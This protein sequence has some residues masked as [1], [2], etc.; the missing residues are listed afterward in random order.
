VT[1]STTLLVA[2]EP[3]SNSGKMKQA[4]DKGIRIVS[5]DEFEAML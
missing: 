1:K 5:I 3:E 4:R 2:K